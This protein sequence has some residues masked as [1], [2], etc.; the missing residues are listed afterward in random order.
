MKLHSVKAIL[1]KH[2]KMWTLQFQQVRN[3]VRDTAHSCMQSTAAISD[4]LL[5][6]YISR[7]V[8]KFK[9]ESVIQSVVT[10]HLDFSN[11]LP[12]VMYLFYTSFHDNYS[13]SI[14]SLHCIDC[15]QISVLL[16]CQLGVTLLFLNTLDKTVS[17]ILILFVF[18]QFS[19]VELSSDVLLP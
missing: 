11:Y 3:A 4:K 12:V 1:N 8:R 17:S 14:Y 6:L 9:G 13:P 18:A 2:D 15:I 10:W 16:F 19:P 7:F 5:L